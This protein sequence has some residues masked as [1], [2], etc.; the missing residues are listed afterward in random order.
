MAKDASKILLLDLEEEMRRSYIDYAMSVIVGRALPDVRDG[1]KPVQ[2][3][4]LY[5]MYEAGMTPDKPHKKSARVVGDV[6]ARFHPHGDA[7][8]YESMVR[9]AQDFAT[10]YPLVDGHG[11]FGSVDGDAPAAMRYTEARLSAIAMELLRDIEKETVDFVP[12]YDGSLEEPVVLPARVPNLLIN[13]SAGIAV[14]M[15]TNI[16]PHN[17]GEVVDAL[18]ALIDDPELDD[19]RLFQLLPGPDFP[20]GGLIVGRQGIEQ[21]YREGRGSLKVRA[22]VRL[23]SEGGRPRLVITEIPYQVN[24]AN[25]VEKIAELVREKK[26]EGITDLRDESDRNG[27]RVVLELRRDTNT[28]VLLNQLYKHTQLEETFGVILLA[29]VDGQPRLLTIREMLAHYLAHQEEMVRRRSQFELRKAE[30]RAHIVLGLRIAL[31]HLDAVI[32]TIRQSRDPDAAREALMTHFGLSERQ[33]QAILDM[34]LQR[35]TAL[36]REKLEAEYADLLKEIDRLKTILAD[37]ELIRGVVRDELLAVKEKFADERRTT[38]VEAEEEVKEEDLVAEEEVAVTITGRGYIKRLPVDTYRSQ[39]R[40]GRGVAGVTVREDDV[41]EHL[42][43]CST[44]A[45]LLFFTDSGKVYRLKVYEIPEGSRQ[46]RGLPLVNLLPIEKET[47]TA[48]VA[49]QDFARGYL[50]MA[51][52]RGVVK[53]TPLAELATVRR[54][55]IIA[56][57]LDEG[58]SLVGV[59]VTSGDD[60]IMLVSGT[61]LLIRFKEEEVRSMGRAARGVKGMEVD[62]DDRVVALVRPTGAQDLLVVTEQGFGKRTELGAYRLQSR[63]GRGVLTIRSDLRRGRVVTAKAVKEED[64]ILLISTEGEVIRLAVRE[65]PRQ[66]RASQGVTLMRLPEN[67]KIAAVALI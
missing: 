42:F 1:L 13:G 2:R 3:R 21:A 15:A 62:P 43:I 53:R 39:R 12:N 8:V 59:E 34:R 37:P 51:T 45:Y 36:E 9:M 60:E 5:A 22:R 32:K 38:I 10:R 49:V 29:L 52:A 66:G 24:K 48:V 55:G 30:E 44:H 4:I 54:D 57:S 63:G 41:V 20:T 25:L 7:A 61:G 14:G 56:I 67:E 28:R 19:A 33:A 65:I 47:I 50:F 23:E 58:D 6:L 18:V 11:N 31:Q 46:A 16:P 35:L 26:V 64:E 40:G 27:L 17:L